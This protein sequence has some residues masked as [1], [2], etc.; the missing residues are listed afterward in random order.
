V[1]INENNEGTYS[2]TY[3]T[4]KAG[5]SKLSVVVATQF[6]GTGEIKNAPFSVA[7]SAGKVDPSKFKWDGLELDAQGRRSWSLARLTRLP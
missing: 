3:T 2:A 6:N 7:V 5:T 1:K 4:R